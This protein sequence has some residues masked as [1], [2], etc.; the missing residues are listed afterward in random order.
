MIT[1][2]QA[3]DSVQLTRTGQLPSNA[4]DPVGRI[5]AVP[6]LKDRGLM[7]G[8]AAASVCRDFTCQASVTVSEELRGELA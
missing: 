8:Q 6:L 7:D 1:H 3:P 5:A 2:F 4:A